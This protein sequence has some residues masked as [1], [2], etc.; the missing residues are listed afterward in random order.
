MNSYQ[1]ILVTVIVQN[2]LLRLID[3]LCYKRSQWNS[4]YLVYQANIP[5]LTG[6][7]Y[8]SNTSY[9]NYYNHYVLI[10][11]NISYWLLRLKV[12]LCNKHSKWTSY[13][14]LVYQVTIPKLKGPKYYC[15]TSIT[16]TRLLLTV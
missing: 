1:N 9:L 11:I 3:S 15:N 16:T 7:K 14:Y 10:I 2:L 12:C 13:D 5:K 8:Y 4:Y 6:P